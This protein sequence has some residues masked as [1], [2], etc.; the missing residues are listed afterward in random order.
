MHHLSR[1]L[2]LKILLPT[3]D[4]PRHPESPQTRC[5]PQCFTVIYLLIYYVTMF[6]L[7]PDVYGSVRGDSLSCKVSLV[8]VLPFYKPLTI[9]MWGVLLQMLKYGAPS[10]G[11]PRSLNANLMPMC[12]SQRIGN[13]RG[14]PPQNKSSKTARCAR[15]A[16]RLTGPGCWMW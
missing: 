10:F 16:A 14:L 9:P 11:S 8:V 3:E 7:V 4:P 2:F 15:A 5:H 6:T 12:T 13:V 1:L